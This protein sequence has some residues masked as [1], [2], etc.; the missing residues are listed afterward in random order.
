MAMHLSPEAPPLLFAASGPLLALHIAG[1]TVALI[2]GAT[3]MVA[4]KGGRLHRGA[5]NVFFVAMMVMG[6]IGGSVAPF[7]AEA[8]WTNT[9]AG[10]FTVYLVASAWATVRRRP[11]EVG[12]YEKVAVVVPSGVAL[13]G[14]ALL[15]VGIAQDRL[16]GFAPVYVFALIAALA[17]VCDLRVIRRGGLAGVDRLAR[18]VWRI[19]LGFFVATGSFFFGQ[20]DVLPQLIRDTPLPTV[21][22]L[23]P[24]V[25]MIFWLIRV[26]YPHGFRRMR[27]A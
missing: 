24:L 19:S 20:G 16:A 22:G 18:H 11:G 15:A 17:A 7:L 3:A 10:L 2:S 6:G 12:L 26:R 27:P 9:T 21:L 5:G 1:G 4:G 25:L 23:A 14:L 8:R 13:M